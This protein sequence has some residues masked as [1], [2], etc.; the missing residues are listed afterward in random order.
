[1][2]IRIVWI[3]NVKPMAKGWES[4]VNKIEKVNN[5]G[6]VNIKISENS[7]KKY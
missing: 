5:K 1:M 7:L 2:E 4:C 6:I 3:N